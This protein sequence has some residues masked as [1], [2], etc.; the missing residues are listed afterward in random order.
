MY[1]ANACS[2]VNSPHPSATGVASRPC[3]SGPAR[4][5]TAR[6]RPHRTRATGAH[7]SFR[8]RG[9]PHPKPQVTGDLHGMERSVSVAVPIRRASPS[10]RLVA[11]RPSGSP[12]DLDHA[13]A[14]GPADAFSI[15]DCH[16]H[17]ARAAGA[18]A[19]RAA[20]ARPPV[21]RPGLDVDD[22][23]ASYCVDRRVDRDD[24]VPRWVV[25]VRAWQSP[26]RGRSRGGVTNR[27]GRIRG[28]R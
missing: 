16:S 26:G 25:V 22:G 10:S 14:V 11:S 15:P 6:G 12:S 17:A 18:S 23:A 8:R 24:P 20:A 13:V 7:R 4:I 21:V 1:D 5:S 19:D 2:G 9:E 3:W 27:G 28:C